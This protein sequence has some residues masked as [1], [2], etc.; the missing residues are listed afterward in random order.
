[1]LSIIPSVARLFS[2][3]KAREIS[4]CVCHCLLSNDNNNVDI[5]ID[6]IVV[7]GTG[8]NFTVQE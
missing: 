7:M 4:K 5:Y 2:H 1:M 8:K 6:E 3:F